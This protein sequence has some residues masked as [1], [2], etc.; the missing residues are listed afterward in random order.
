LID[1]QAVPHLKPTCK[2][3][4]LWFLCFSGHKICGPTFYMERILAK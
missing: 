1:A 3:V 4:R 2:R